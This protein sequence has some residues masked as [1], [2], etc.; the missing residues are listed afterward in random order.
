MPVPISFT[1]NM[2]RL[3][4]VKGLAAPE[5]TI[6]PGAVQDTFGNLIVGTFDVSTATFDNVILDVSGQDASPRGMAF[7]ND[8]AKMFVVGWDGRSIHEYALPTPFD[9]TAAA[10]V[11]HSTSRHR[12]QIQ[13]AWRFQTTAPRCSWWMVVE[14][15]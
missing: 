13:R 3:E 14:M 12:T 4:T 11:R 7:S 5:L 6:E 8:G 10:H 1:L 15:T 9:V 2:S